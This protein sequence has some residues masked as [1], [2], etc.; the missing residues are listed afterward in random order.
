MQQR[1]H[2]NATT[3]IHLRS[4]IYKSTKSNTELSKHYSVSEKTIA[5]WKN[6]AKFT[7]KSS[8]PHTITYAL[9]E[10]DQLIAQS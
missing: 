8:K 10:L 4:T 7:D 9:S 2:R 3:N 6:R 5:K 1:Y